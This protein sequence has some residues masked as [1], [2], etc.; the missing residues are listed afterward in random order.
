MPACKK[1]N[2]PVKNALLKKNALLCQKKQQKK[3]N[4]KNS[5]LPSHTQNDLGDV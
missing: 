5:P 1:M 3:K 4:A 2:T